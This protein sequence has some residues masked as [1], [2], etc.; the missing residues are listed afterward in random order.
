MQ[1]KG[2]KTEWRGARRCGHLEELRRPAQALS[3]RV[4]VLIKMILKSSPKR[5][6]QH[7]LEQTDGVQHGLM[8]IENNHWVVKLIYSH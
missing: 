4:A 5:H 2:E 6:Q 8:K 3:N 7:I 1:K